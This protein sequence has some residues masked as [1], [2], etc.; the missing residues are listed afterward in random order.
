MNKNEMQLR[1]P[2]ECKVYSTIGDCD[3]RIIDEH[4][5]RQWIEI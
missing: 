2:S 3:I 4:R 1:M 5:R